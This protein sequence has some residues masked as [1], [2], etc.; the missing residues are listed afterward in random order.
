MVCFTLWIHGV[1]MIYAE[2]CS[3]AQRLL[4]GVTSWTNWDKYTKLFKY[5]THK[6]GFTFYIYTS[7]IYFNIRGIFYI[8]YVWMFE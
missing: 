7:S 1:G 6:R 5:N 4:K 2:P 3:L 8:K